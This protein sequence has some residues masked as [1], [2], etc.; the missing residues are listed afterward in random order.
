MKSGNLAPHAKS[1]KR[2]LNWQCLASMTKTLH[3]TR[4]TFHFILQCLHSGCPEHAEYQ[5]R[6][7][8]IRIS[9]SKLGR[10]KDSDGNLI[11]P[12]EKAK[13]SFFF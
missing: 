11:N 5:S 9:H 10:K 7:N 12:C 6:Q 4:R 8:L 13:G 3:S 1:F 2:W